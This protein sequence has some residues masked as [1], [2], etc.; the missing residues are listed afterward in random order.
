MLCRKGKWNMAYIA[1][2]FL[3]AKRHNHWRWEGKVGLPNTQILEYNAS[4]WELAK[5]KYCYVTNIH[6]WFEYSMTREMETFLIIPRRSHSSKVPLD[7]FCSQH[8]IM[9]VLQPL[10]TWIF[11]SGKMHTTSEW[12]V[13]VPLKKDQ[14]NH[15]DMYLVFTAA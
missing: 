15:F 6:A 11:N 9:T 13:Q 8:L 7:I 12:N 2:E 1:R 5:V 3:E 14:R 4:S 10:Q